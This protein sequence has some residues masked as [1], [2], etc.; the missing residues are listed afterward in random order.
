MTENNFAEKIDA[1]EVAPLEPV[2]FP[3]RV[4]IVENPDD[5]VKACE[6]LLSHPFIG[7]DT[8]TRPSFRAGSMNK[9][10]LL[11]L[12]TPHTCYLFRLC[13]MALEKPIQKVLESKTTI[14]IGADILNDIRALQQLRHFRP[15]GFV[16]LQSIAEQWGIGEKSVRKMSAIIL[17]RRV[18]KAQRLSNWEATAL[19]GAQ[20]TYAATDAW[21][22]L[23][24]YEELERTEKNPLPEPEPAPPKEPK[25]P[26]PARRCPYRRFAKRKDRQC[27]PASADPAADKN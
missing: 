25:E 20:C 17:G 18:S 22:C 7:F 15:D 26:K 13:R 16:D 10:A 1:A 23:R 8:E 3:G 24:M 9:V 12:S 6:D 5:A 11:Q 4:V 27:D 14:K 21:V 19:T 2:R